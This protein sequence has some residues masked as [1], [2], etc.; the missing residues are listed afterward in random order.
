MRHTAWLAL[1]G[2]LGHA[3]WAQRGPGNGMGGHRGSGGSPGMHGGGQG[4]YRRGGTAPSPAPA[5]APA[6]VGGVHVYTPNTY[7]SPLGYGNVVFPGTGHMPGTYSPFSIVDPTF[8]TR[9]TNTVSGFGYPYGY[10]SG[11]Y[12]SGYSYGYGYRAPAVV[13]YA[14]PVYVP[15]ADP[16][17]MAP[18][19]PPAPPQIIYVLPGPPSATVVTTAPQQPQNGVVTYVVPPRNGGATES[20]APR[21][22][23]IALKNSSIY[24]AA[25]YWVEDDTLHYVTNHG[26]HNQVSLDQFDLELTKRLNRER[27][28]DFRLHQ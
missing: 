4:G 28:L 11:Y 6:R 19:P 17:A 24:S 14:V 27:G 15:Y 21:L 7:G 1:V 25:E 26:V 12:G 16:Y 3:A 2:L 9:L 10:S 5:P 18:P 22:Y 23:L 20:T 13:P 8:G